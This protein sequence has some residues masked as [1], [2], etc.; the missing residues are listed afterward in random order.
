MALSE[1]SVSGRRQAAATSVADLS[2][3]QAQ[4][5]AFVE[6]FPGITIQD[7]AVKYG[8]SHPTAAYHLSMLAKRGL[9]RRSRDGRSLRH[10]AVTSRT[11]GD[12]QYLAALERD[13]RRRRIIDFLRTE[14]LSNVSI[15]QIRERL[16]LPYGLIRRTL[17]QLEKQGLVTLHAR[18]YTYLIELRGPWARRLPPPAVEVRDL[19]PAPAAD[20]DPGVVLAR[21]P[22][23]D[24]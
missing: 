14:D 12:A 1:R 23:Q 5:L 24:P 21:L 19:P 16:Q 8:C 13:E 4:V 18:R 11:G 22:L 20:A 3:A 6:E 15:N 9:L 10:Y 17:V 2:L 7:I